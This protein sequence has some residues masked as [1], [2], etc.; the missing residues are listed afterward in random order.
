MV[1]NRRDAFGALIVLLDLAAASGHAQV[2]AAGSSAPRPPVFKHDLPNISLDGWELTVNHVD[3]PPGRVGEPHRH[4]G[5]VLAYVLEGS[6]IAKIIGEGVSDEERTYQ[7]G[8]MFYE[9]IGAIHQVAKN[10]SSTK[11]ARLLAIN[12]AKKGE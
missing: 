2:Q 7:A 5:L 8:E 11:P 12:F 6:V 3:Y 10:A 9:P 1:L 4:R